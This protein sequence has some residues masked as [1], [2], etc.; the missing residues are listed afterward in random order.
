MCPLGEMEAWRSQAQA[1]H[2]VTWVFTG[3]LWPLQVN[4]WKQKGLDRRE[5]SGW[6]PAGEMARRSYILNKGP[7]KF[8]PEEE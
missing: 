7:M 8:T 3:F 1:W 6:N 2:P 4:V 5:T